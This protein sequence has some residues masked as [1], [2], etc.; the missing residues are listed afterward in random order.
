[1]TTIVLISSVSTIMTP[2]VSSVVL[3]ELLLSLDKQIGEN[4]S[5]TVEICTI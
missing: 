4:M 1:M 3:I 2:I 5:I